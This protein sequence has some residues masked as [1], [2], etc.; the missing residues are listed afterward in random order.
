MTMIPVE[1]MTYEIHKILMLSP[2][3]LHFLVAFC[4]QFSQ[5]P[6]L[7]YPIAIY[8]EVIK[9]YRERQHN[10][11]GKVSSGRG[12]SKSFNLLDISISFMICSLTLPW[13]LYLAFI[14]FFISILALALE[15]PWKCYSILAMN[16]I[17]LDGVLGRAPLMMGSI[18]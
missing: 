10:I 16:S 12:I 17:S 9:N 1:V 7:V 6:L 4:N 15:E 13:P 14:I 18:V 2:Q 8:L 11:V 3:P 5:A